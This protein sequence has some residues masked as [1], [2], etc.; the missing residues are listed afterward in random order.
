MDE[1]ATCLH[2]DCARPMKVAL[3]L[4]QLRSLQVVKI[5]TQPL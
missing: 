4:R 5:Q 1:G 2:G 3:L